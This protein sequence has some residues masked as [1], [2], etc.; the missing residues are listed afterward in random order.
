MMDALIQVA[1]GFIAHPY[2]PA[3]VWFRIDYP[4]ATHVEV[5]AQSN[6]VA[7]TPGR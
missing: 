3:E 7:H 1:F 5:S 2:G 6:E 4:T